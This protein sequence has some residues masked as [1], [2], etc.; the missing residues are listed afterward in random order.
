MPPWLADDMPVDETH[1][2]ECL[3]LLTNGDGRKVALFEKPFDLEDFYAD[4]EKADA[5]TKEY[6]IWREEEREKEKEEAKCRKT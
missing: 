6:L 5:R 3:C 2:P 1:F 4:L